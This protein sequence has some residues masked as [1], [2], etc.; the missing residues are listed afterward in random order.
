MALYILI[1]FSSWNHQRLHHI[2]L[3]RSKAH[4]FKILDKISY[5]YIGSL[6]CFSN[7]KTRSMHCGGWRGWSNHKRRYKILSNIHAYDICIA[8]YICLRMWTKILKYHVF[9]KS[10]FATCITF[11]ERTFDLYHERF[12]L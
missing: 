7:L 3:I 1:F 2:H 12:Y 10:I 11:H 8:R 4:Y 6:V 9:H 5:H